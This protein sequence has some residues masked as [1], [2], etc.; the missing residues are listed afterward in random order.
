MSFASSSDNPD[1]RSLFFAAKAT[2]RFQTSQEI[3]DKALSAIQEHWDRKSVPSKVASTVFSTFL[4]QFGKRGK[5][6]Y[7]AKS[8]SLGTMY[9]DFLKGKPEIAA[10]AP[11][12]RKVLDDM[13]KTR[14]TSAGPRFEAEYDAI[15]SYVASQAS[16][17]LVLEAYAALFV[18]VATK[19][20]SEPTRY[21]FGDLTFDHK[22][23]DSTRAWKLLVPSLLKNGRVESLL[24]CGN[25]T[26][27]FTRDIPE[28]TLGT[29]VS[30]LFPKDICGFVSGLPSKFLISL[31]MIQTQHSLREALY[32]EIRKAEAIVSKG[33]KI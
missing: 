9:V 31:Y 30:Q 25:N 4:S 10:L 29:T 21:S 7:S 33:G 14:Q 2:P 11:G 26:L 18:Q 12:L 13:G 5:E 17:L 27:Y 8:I 22:T 6:E 3:Q 16:L 20:Q 15:S 24:G 1:A 32:L 28:S 23:A 19:K